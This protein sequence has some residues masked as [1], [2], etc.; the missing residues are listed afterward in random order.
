MK[1]EYFNSFSE[2][3]AVP[4]NNFDDGGVPLLVPANTPRT[5]GF[6]QPGDVVVLHVKTGDDNIETVTVA[7]GHISDVQPSLL[8]GGV[9]GVEV[10]DAGVGTDTLAAHI[11]VVTGGEGE[12]GGQADHHQDQPHHLSQSDS[13]SQ[14]SPPPEVDDDSWQL[15]SFPPEKLL[16]GRARPLTGG[17]YEAA[18]LSSA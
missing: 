6:G 18:Q 13:A 9:G 16:V 7:R 2:A 1:K 5:E 3:E 14:V 17:K 10:D 4:D 11:I 15:P 12:V 8:G